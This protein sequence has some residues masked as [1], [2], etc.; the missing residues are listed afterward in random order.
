VER[1]RMEEVCDA[2]IMK[3][4]IKK[5]E[6]AMEIFKKLFAKIIKTKN[7]MSDYLGIQG[8]Y[9]V[10]CL[11]INGNLKWE[12][13]IKNVVTTVGKNA[14][15]DA[16]LAGNAFTVVGP[17]MGLISSVGYGAGAV[18][19]DT[20]TSHTGWVEAGFASNFPLYTAPRK[21]CVWSLAAS[22]IKSLSASL[23]F[24][25]AG[26]GGTVKGCFLVF[27]PGA[28]STINDTNGILL[29]AGTFT[30]GDKL[31]GD[32]DTLQISYSMNS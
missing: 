6:T 29:S 28:V 19:G 4:K 18:V 25:C 17:F 8:T 15:L 31:I 16:A 5:M 1:I 7:T 13:S 27:G 2:I 9:F 10:Q 23:S 22:G 24:V 21:T 14:M 11:D 30:G 26:T 32:G 3:K 20:M 12:D